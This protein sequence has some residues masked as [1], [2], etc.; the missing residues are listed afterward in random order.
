M[1]L[2]EETK[3]KLRE[4]RLGDKNPFYGRK[5]SE[6]TRIKMRLARRDQ[7][8]SNETRAKL[9]SSKLGEKNPMWKGNDS[10]HNTTLH[11]W[12]RDHLPEP[13]LCQMCNR[14]PP[15]DLANITDIYSRD[16]SNWQYLCRKCHME[17]DG[18]MKNLDQTIDMSGRKCFMCGSSKTRRRKSRNNRELWYRL[19]NE[20]I[21]SNC[22]TR[23]TRR[24]RSKD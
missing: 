4:M 24:S 16:F 18:R 14:V 23:G 6:E 9:S 7:E 15:Y 22:Y 3:K 5:H 21:C 10:I 12:V 20:F 19:G 2:T 8:Y 1:K 11:Q 17:S 13:E